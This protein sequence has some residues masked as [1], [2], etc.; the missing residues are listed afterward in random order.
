MG[1]PLQPYP[2]NECGQPGYLYRLR[3]GRNYSTCDRCLRI[4]DVATMFRGA[5]GWAA[6]EWAEVCRLRAAEKAEKEKSRA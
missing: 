3:D 4:D 5:V 1:D 6:V 2:C